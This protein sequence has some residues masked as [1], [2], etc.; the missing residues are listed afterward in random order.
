[1]EGNQLDTVA[2]A[3]DFCNV[4]Y[5]LSYQPLHSLPQIA[6]GES[7]HLYAS[8]GAFP[9]VFVLP[10]SCESPAS[11]SLDAVLQG[12]LPSRSGILERQPE[13]R[14]EVRSYG[15]HEVEVAAALPGNG[16]L[17]VTD[18]WYPGW[19]AIVDG[20]PVTIQRAYGLFRSVGLPAGE[21]VV[22]F[23]YAPRSLQIGAL[24]SLLGGV[25]VVAAAAPGKRRRT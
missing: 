17:V 9:R 2:G 8:R 10:D 23:R 18:A 19:R 13:W 14:A 1:M 21:H 11:G 16:H 24:L 6:E 20:K 25:T 7:W 5:L 4:R 15:R 12:R 22:R 3:L